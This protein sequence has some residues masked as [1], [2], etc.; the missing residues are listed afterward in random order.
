MI[1][2]LSVLLILNSCTNKSDKIIG[3]WERIDDELSGMTIEVKKYGDELRGEIIQNCKHPACNRWIIGDVKWKNIKHLEDNYFEFESL[4]KGAYDDGS[5][6]LTSYS[7]HKVE[8]F[9]DS[10]LKTQKYAKG[11]E[12]IG[13][14]QTYRK[15]K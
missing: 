12:V 14:K 2:L 3:K 8:L 13:T 5:V 7:L 10:V 11:R 6:I 1:S 4:S 9:G 15:V